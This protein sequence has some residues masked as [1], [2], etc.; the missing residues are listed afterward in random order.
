MISRL[1]SL[2]ALTCVFFT[3]TACFHRPNRAEMAGEACL[4]EARAHLDA[5]RYA[6]ARDVIDSLR[7]AYP[8]ALN[9]REQAILLLDSVEWKDAEAQLLAPGL[10]PDSVEELRL[11]SEFFQKKLQHDIKNTG[12]KK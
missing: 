12:V 10:S 6:A 9:S 3:C 4:K 1:L 2:L 8:L 11:K 5:G 7:T